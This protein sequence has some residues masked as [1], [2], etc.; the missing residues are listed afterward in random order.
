MHPCSHVVT[1]SCDNGARLQCSS[2]VMEI[3]KILCKYGRVVMEIDRVAKWF[4][5]EGKQSRKQEQEQDWR[6]VWL[7]SGLAL[8]RDE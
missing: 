8:Q 1:Q 3:E 4:G 2:V 7:A 6:L 5:R